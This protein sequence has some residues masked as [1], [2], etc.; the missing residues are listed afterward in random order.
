M[1][2]PAYPKIGRRITISQGRERRP[3]STVI[4]SASEAIQRDVDRVRDTWIA[5]SAFGLLAMTI[6]AACLTFRRRVDDELIVGPL[7]EGECVLHEAH[8]AVVGVIE[9]TKPAF[10][11]LN[12]LLVPRF[13]E[14][15]A[16]GPERLDKEL[17]LRVAE[18]AGEVRA[19]FGEQAPGSV[20]PGG[21]ELASRGLEK[22][23]T[24]E[25]ALTIAVQPAAKEPRRRFVPAARVPEAVEA[26]GGYSI[27]LTAAIREGGASAEGPR[28][29]SGSTRPA[30]LN[31]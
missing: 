12:G 5:T 20:L 29:P 24:Q 1:R 14:E 25:V 18:G 10:A 2:L 4:A 23:V 8:G 31:K 3:L 15:R 30:S 19:K 27:A 26:I 9:Q 28:D 22:H 7:G 21:N 13:R 6:T 11:G 17:D 16:L